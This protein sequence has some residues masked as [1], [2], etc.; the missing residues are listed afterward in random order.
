[1]LIRGQNSRTARRKEVVTGS[2]PSANPC[3]AVP[4]DCAAGWNDSPQFAVANGFSDTDGNRTRVPTVSSTVQRVS[5]KQASDYAEVFDGVP[6]QHDGKDAAV[7]AE[8]AA[9]GKSWPWPLP[10]PSEVEQELAY[11]VDWADAQRRQRMQWCGRLEALLSRPWP[12]AT[13]TVRLC[14][15]TLLGILAHYGGPHGL[16]QAPERRSTMKRIVAVAIVLSLSGLAGVARADDKKNDPTG[17]WKYE[18]EFNGQKRPVTIKLKLEGDKLT[19]SVPGRNNTETKIEDGKFK[20]GDVSFTV[21]RERNGQKFTQKYSG[22][23]DGDT[24]KGKMEMERDGQ[25]I[26]REFEAKREKS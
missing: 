2:R 19:G 4:S 23:I 6:S 22:K 11:Q 26:T 13:R 8:L 9:Q 5:P 24:F 10:V 20:D 14:S 7:I 25:N 15:G 17:T 12:E 16:A 3:L 21:T 1:M 18:A